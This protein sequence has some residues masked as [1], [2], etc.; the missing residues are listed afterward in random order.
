M[1]YKKT[2][3][4]LLTLISLFFFGFEAFAVNIDEYYEVQ[5]EASGA[6]ELSDY[7]SQETRGYLD[8]LGC[9]DIE[10]E[11]ILEISPKAIF[12]MMFGI[13][14][15]GIKEPLSG[16][17]KAMGIVLMVSVC[18]GFFP[19]DEKSKSIL[20]IVCGCFM[21][22]GI[23]SSATESLKAA[24]SAIG[25]CAAFEKALIPVLAA[26][27]TVSGNPT[28][29]LTYKGAAFAA[30]EFIESLAKNFSLPLIGAS[31]ALGVTGAML[32]TLRLSAI[33]EIIRKTMITVLTCSASLFMG[34]LAMKNIISSSA[35]SLAAK[36]VRLA[37]STFVPVV[38]GAL[39][40]A[41]SSVIG[42]ISLLRSAI[43]V[44]AIIVF[45]VTGIPVV[46]NLALWVISIRIASSVSDLLDCRVCSDV[47]KNIAFIFS[48]ANALL[49]LCMAVFIISAGLVV[50]IKSGG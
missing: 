27:V 34:F 13:L 11:K 16:M 31:G 2:F 28:M 43:G 19:D 35:D 21:I 49:L 41:Y 50:L 46:I 9:G 8:E 44:Y 17:L 4:L 32:P 42:S 14:K 40:E 24:V 12:E 30:A 22:I 38:G 7:L 47:L 20:N 25:A 3:I 36:G 48:T 29:A 23:F 5:L 10:F 18:S 39:S 37:T 15:N 45:F 1:K 33:G 6:S 26:V